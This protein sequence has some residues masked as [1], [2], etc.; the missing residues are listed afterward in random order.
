MVKTKEIV[1]RDMKTNTG[2]RIEYEW[3]R[4]FDA[5]N[6]HAIVSIADHKGTITYV[7]DLFCE[8]SGFTRDELIGNNHRI[9]KSDEHSPEF[10]K[11]MWRTIAN[12]NIWK[13]E[14][15]NKRKDGSI[16]WVE[17]TITPYMDEQGKPY[18]YVSIR[19]DITHVKSVQQR[20]EASNSILEEITSSAQK[21]I[22]SSLNDLNEKIEFILNDVARHLKADAACVATFFDDLSY[23]ID[24]LWRD[25]KADS[26]F[27][28]FFSQ[29]IMRRVEDTKV[30]YFVDDLS[31]SHGLGF[32]VVPVTNSVSSKKYIVF[33]IKAIDLAHLSGFDKQILVFAEVLG[34]AISRVAA[35][36]ELIEVKERLRLGQVF[37]N[38]GTWE[39]NIQN[40]N[41]YWSEKIAPLFGYEEGSVETSY[42]NFI[43]AVHPDD[44]EIVQSAVDK[45][46]HHECPYEVEHRI[47]K[48][49]GTVRWLSEKGAVIRDKDNN[50]IKMIGVVQDID[51]RKS[52]QIELEKRV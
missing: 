44:R 3:E 32:Y 31:P 7:N 38:I 46:V 26:P 17:S 43:D 1:D 18:Q 14:I 22:V 49:D 4:Q 2:D 27:N 45:A 47:V 50:P 28:N 16:Y 24:A 25:V 8:I 12:G 15:C 21:L 34:N 30:S 13:G 52:A 9:V 40:G 51:E 41:L 39:W 48:T 11:N 10:F 29:S 36:E 42:Q 19:T 5:L 6:H 35:N 20:L 23:K 37:A 33:R